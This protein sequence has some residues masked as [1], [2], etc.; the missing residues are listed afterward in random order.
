MDIARFSLVQLRYFVVAA[1]SG[2]M[3]AA[4]RALMVSQSAIST[5]VAQLEGQLGVTLFVRHH[6]RGLSLTPVGVRFLADARALL[7]HA[8]EISNSAR[9]LSR[10]VAGDLILGCFLTLAPVWL[11]RLITAVEERHPAMSLRVTEADS[12]ALRESLLSGRCELALM[13][14]Y[15][16]DSSDGLQNELISTV[17]PYVIVSAKHRLASRGRIH[18]MELAEDPMVLYDPPQS[19]EYFQRVA[20]LAGLDPVVRYRSTSL[21]T[22]RAL[23][24]SGHGYSIVHQRPVCDITYDGGNLVKLGLADDLPSLA[25]VLAHADGTR[26]TRRAAAF[27]A[28]AHEILGESQ[29]TVP[30]CR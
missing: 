19:R 11:P 25:I 22:V 14:D 12:A 27:S 9:S 4:A 16:D 2:S 18:L 17:V 6:A 29:A 28:I 1:R 30:G 13:Y 7:A 8:E 3:T 10:D 5:S 23:V 21:E 20:A 24:A 15:G 26:P